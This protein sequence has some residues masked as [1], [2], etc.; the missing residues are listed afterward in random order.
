[1]QR[2]NDTQ[3]IFAYCCLTNKLNKQHPIVGY[4]QESNVPLTAGIEDEIQEAL[5]RQ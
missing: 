3:F 5:K 4:S 1:M 2:Q